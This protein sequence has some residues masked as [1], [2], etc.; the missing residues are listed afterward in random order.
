MIINGENDKETKLRRGTDP[1]IDRLVVRNFKSIGEDGIDIELKPLTIFLGP[2]GSGKSSVLESISALSQSVGKGIETN[3]QGKNL[4][5]IPI[6]SNI[7]HKKSK[8]WLTIEIYVIPD[9]VEL[10]RLTNSYNMQ[11][12][13]NNEKIQIQTKVTLSKDTR[14]GYSLSYKWETKEYMHIVTRGDQKIAQSEYIKSGE[15]SW[16]YRLEFPDLPLTKPEIGPDRILVKGLFTPKL[17]PGQETVYQPSSDIA[18]EIVKIITDH[19]NHTIFPISA[20]RGKINDEDITAV[21]DFDKETLKILGVG[22]NGQYLV[23]ILNILNNVEYE[24]IREKIDKWASIFNLKKLS[25]STRGRGI[26]GLDYKDDKLDTALNIYMASQGSR[27]VLPI[28]TQLFW[29]DPGSII[30]IEEPEISLHPDSQEELAKL[31][32]EAIKDEKQIIITTHSTFLPL[33][34]GSLIRNKLLNIEDIAIYQ[35]KKN[36]NGTNAERIEITPTGITKGMIYYKSRE[37]SEE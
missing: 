1:M 29:S 16:N 31:F 19:V 24:D 3:T 8:N 22:Q 14:I 13:N 15:I 2:N 37:E 23:S 10:N 9:D 30:M 18:E 28:I 4:I 27:Q 11:R 33:A 21:I 36:D 26:R 6:V 12:K 20:M 17:D 5:D 25:A 7:F 35:F 32:V 34:L